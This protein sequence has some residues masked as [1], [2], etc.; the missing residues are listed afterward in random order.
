MMSFSSLQKQRVGSNQPLGMAIAAVPVVASIYLPLI[1]PPLA[2]LI[3]LALAAVVGA[4]SLFA[5]ALSGR[6]IS[7]EKLLP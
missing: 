4:F 7:R 1:L 3:D 2:F 6:L 5:Y